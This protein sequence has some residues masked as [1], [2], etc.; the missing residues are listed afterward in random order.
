M[1]QIAVDALNAVNGQTFEVINAA[2]L[3]ELKN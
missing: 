1:A 2:D 3:C